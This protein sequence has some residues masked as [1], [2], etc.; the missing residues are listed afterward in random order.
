V[1]SGGKNN[2]VAFFSYAHHDALTDPRLV[3]AFTSELERHVNAK[4]ANAEFSIWRDDKGLRTGDRW[5]DDLQESVAQADVL[6]VLLTPRWLHSAYCRKE[7]DTF[8]TAETARAI[9]NYVAPILA[10]DLEHQLPFLTEEQAASYRAVR[11]RQSK[12]ALAADFLRLAG[13]ERKLLVDQLADDIERML[14]R[15]RRPPTPVVPK[16]GAPRPTDPAARNFE[17]ADVVVDG[18]PQFPRPQVSPDTGAPASRTQP[19]SS[20]LD[21]FIPAT[22]QHLRPSILQ[23]LVHKTRS[24][25]IPAHITDAMDGLVTLWMSHQSDG[26]PADN[27]YVHK[28]GRDGFDPNTGLPASFSEVVAPYWETIKREV[29]EPNKGK[30]WVSKYRLGMSDRPRLQLEV[31]WTNYWTSRCLERAFK[32]GLRKQYEMSDRIF[33]DLPSM[34]GSS[35]VILTSDERLILAQRKRGQTDF[36]DGQWSASFEEQWDFDKDEYPHDAVI[37]GLSEEFNLDQKHG[38]AVGPQNI[39]LFAF[40]REWGQFWNVVML[41]VVRIPATATKV[42]ECWNSIPPPHDK[43]EHAVLAAVPLKD[44]AGKDFLIDLLDRNSTIDEAQL[45]RVSGTEAISRSFLSD[46][47]P[48]G[49]HPSS[50]RARILMGLWAAGCLDGPPR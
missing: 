10:R 48:H 7:F 14:T 32:D 40:A 13:D 27:V 28:I 42:L 43:H 1:A 30:V 20:S 33:Y 35:A 5:D 26:L 46:D 38:V 37:R 12:K 31:G 11:E 22:A 24:G 19:Q 36:A 25:E 9:G 29:G 41:Y 6:I 18:R 45:E 47:K 39:R 34:V 44:R 21:A 49:L 23:Q 4:L 50:G 2:F 8:V 16:T 15:L 17:K 3:E